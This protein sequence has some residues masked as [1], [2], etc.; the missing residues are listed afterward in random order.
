MEPAAERDGADPQSQMAELSEEAE[1]CILEQND[2]PMGSTQPTFEVS[3]T[4]K[5]LKVWL[6]EPEAQQTLG[7]WTVWARS[8]RNAFFAVCTTFLRL[9]APALL[10]TPQS[11]RHPSGQH[12][13]NP[14]S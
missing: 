2:L 8:R 5:P 1:P 10:A 6:L 4:P 3:D 14:L 9:F 11:L 13:R 7:T 12:P